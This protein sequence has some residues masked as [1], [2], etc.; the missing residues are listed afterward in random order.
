MGHVINNDNI[1]SVIDFLIDGN[2][3]IGD[4]DYFKNNTVGFFKTDKNHEIRF[5]CILTKNLDGFWILHIRS[6]YNYKWLTQSTFND[7][8]KCIMDNKLIDVYTYIFPDNRTERVLH[9]LKEFE[10]V[11][12]KNGIKLYHA[13]Y[14]FLIKD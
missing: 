12:E 9:N 7:Y 14:N 13:N 11:G 1:Q 8:Y 6:K 2:D 10:M 4:Q 3:D 5:V